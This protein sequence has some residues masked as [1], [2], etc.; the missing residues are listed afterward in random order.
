MKYTVLVFFRKVIAALTAFLAALCVGKTTPV[1]PERPAENTVGVYNEADADYALSIGADAEIDEISELLFGIFF[2]DINFAADGGL[3]AE[4]AVNRSFEFSE[5]AAGD[6]LYGWSAVGGAA[7]QVVTDQPQQALNENNPNFVTVK[8]EADAPA[9]LANRGFLDG[10]A[11]EQGKKY[12]LSFY[13][14]SGSY[15]GDVTAR[16]CVGSEIAGEAT[17]RV[18][19]NGWTKYNVV[20]TADRTA[21]ENVTLQLLTGKGEL[22]FD[23][24]SLF[25]EDTYKGRDNGLRKD[26][27]QMLEQRT[28]HHIVAIKDFSVFFQIAAAHTSVFAYLIIAAIRQNKVWDKIITHL[29]VCAAHFLK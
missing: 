23:M 5:L 29:T 10:M 4:M 7:L 20:L 16:L 13:A 15:S 21:H 19:G 1:Q 24:I 2:E 25:P 18:A 17:V 11:I 22:C 12:K 14:K 27:G 26:L 3:Y 6:Q 8:N 28:L 9:G